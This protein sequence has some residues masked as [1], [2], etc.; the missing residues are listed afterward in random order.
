MKSKRCSPPP[1]PV[2]EKEALRSLISA[3]DAHAD[4]EAGAE[5][6][7]DGV[8]KSGRVFE[9][10][11]GDVTLRSG[12]SAAA[13]EAIDLIDELTRYADTEQEGPRPVLA[14]FAAA[15]RY[16]AALLRGRH[17]EH[18]YCACLD[19]GGRLIRCA[20]IGRGGFDFSPA[21]VREIAACAVKSG[22]EGVV[23]A[24][25]HPGGTLA[26]S[27]EDVEL[28]RKARAALGVMGIKLIEHVIVCESGQTGIVEK[29]YLE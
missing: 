16:F 12:L 13:A 2:T 25:N 15:C 18:F 17:T 20:L 4:A 14:D 26:P 24:H 5:A 29:G 28:T 3:V 9:L 1:F 27:R 10:D 6:L 21:G 8:T 23:L 19:R 7:L 11:A 22:A